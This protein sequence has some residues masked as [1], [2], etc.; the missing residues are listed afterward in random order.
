M[1]QHLRAL[2]RIVVVE[3]EKD[4]LGVSEPRWGHLIAARLALATRGRLDEGVREFA[5]Q[6]GLSP[7]DTQTA[8]LREGPRW[9]KVMVPMGSRGSPGAELLGSLRGPQ[10]VP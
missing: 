5:V 10:R 4:P 3:Q 2:V 8:G 1:K 9:V 7:I 6:T